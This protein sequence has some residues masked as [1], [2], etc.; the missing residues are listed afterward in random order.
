M[1]KMY[2]IQVQMN[3]KKRCKDVTGTG[4]DLLLLYCFAYGI[5]YTYLMSNLYSRNDI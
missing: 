5:T 2:C 4:L 1:Y 3:V